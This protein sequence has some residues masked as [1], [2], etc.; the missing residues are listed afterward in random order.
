[1]S[2]RFNTHGTQVLALRRRLPPV[3]Y[4]THSED[5]VCQFY[6]AD[7]FNSCTMKSCSFAGEND[8]Y[9]ISGSD[10]FNLYMWRVTDA[11]SKLHIPVA[12][13]C[14]DYFFLFFRSTKKI[15]H[16]KNQWIDSHHMVL[17]GHRSIVNQVRYNPQKCLLASSGVEKIIKIW[18]PFELGDWTGS[19][20]E[21]GPT[22][23]RDIFSHE[24][25]I[26]LSNSTQSMSTHDYSHQNTAED[27]RMMACT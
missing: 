19:L 21:D 25:Y 27:P 1:M 20:V 23:T 11:N 8:E 7:Y 12:Y 2:V 13:V 17:Y 3:L 4:N 24:E 5:S 16:K 26:S 14:D 15:A 22:N 10:D 18:R 9:V 6:H